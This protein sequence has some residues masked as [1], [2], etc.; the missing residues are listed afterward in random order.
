LRDIVTFKA[1]SPTLLDIAEE[2]H[3][4][5]STV[6]RVLAGGATAQRIS[7]ATRARVEASAARLGYR[8]NLLARSL[9]TRRTHTV[10]L[11]VSDIANP[12]FGQMA[13]LI[14]HRL[15]QLGYSLILC[16]S[17]EDLE[18][19]ASYL[20]LLGQKGIDGLILV[21]VAST[22][23]ALLTLV[24]PGLPLVLVDRPIPNIPAAVSTDQHQAVDLLC[25]T[26]ERARVRRIALVSGPSHITTH[27]E[28]AQRIAAR[29]EVI[30]SHDGPAQLETGQQA[31]VKF[32]GA[33]P[34]AVVCTNNFLA[35]GM[36]DAIGELDHRFVIACF[37]ELPMMHLLPLPIVS[38]LQDVPLLAATS[39]SQLL[40]QLQDKPK[41]NIAPVLLPSRM[42]TNRAF[43]RM[44]AWTGA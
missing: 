42:V 38:S 16:N 33:A 17:G 35:Q 18:Q 24:P 8:P 26:L 19:E 13:S 9:R 31:F 7:A 21:P 11:L 29:F 3:T 4:S 5:V 27:H 43:Q 32:L 2:T 6:S 30:A 25:D 40:Q 37:D 23:E 14:E 20:R 12:F 41:T 39:V 28:R 22:S 1:S 44:A 10:A 36:I 34:D 15:H